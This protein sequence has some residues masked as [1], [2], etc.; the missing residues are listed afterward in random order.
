MKKR[1][2]GFSI[3]ELLIVFVILVVLSAIFVP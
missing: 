3:I 1:T 2:Q